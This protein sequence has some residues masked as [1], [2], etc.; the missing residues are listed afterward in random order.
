MENYAW[1]YLVG[2]WKEGWLM[3]T[4]IP[5]IMETQIWI[6]FHASQQGYKWQIITE[7]H[8]F[9][10]ARLPTFEAFSILGPTH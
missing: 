10:C 5:G 8:I 4:S 2:G 6:S 7:Q 3:D 1:L 9:V